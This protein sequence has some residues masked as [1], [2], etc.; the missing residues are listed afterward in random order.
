MKTSDPGALFAGVAWVRDWD[1][2]GRSPYLP[3]DHFRYHLGAAIG[4]NDELA[5]GF[6]VQAEYVGEVKDRSRRL[7]ATSQEPVTGRF[8]FNFRANQHTFIEASVNLPANDDAHATTFGFTCI[9][10]Y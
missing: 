4:L 1:G 7:L 10:R 6:E 9:R 2:W 5:I 8:W 3:I